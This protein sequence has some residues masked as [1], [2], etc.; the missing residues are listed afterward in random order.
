MTDTSLATNGRMG[1][2]LLVFGLA[3]LVMSA[4]VTAVL[5][6]F[7]LDAPG[8]VAIGVLVA[9]TVIA[10][11]TFVLGHRR[12]LRRG[13]QL[14]FA[15]LALGLILLISLLQ[16]VVLVPMVVGKAELPAL[17]AEVQT[18]I[19]ANMAVMALVI[20]VV[21]LLYFAI[22]YF[23]SGWFSRR[24]SMRLATTGRI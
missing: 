22:L 23:T 11:R 24:F 9:A 15:L 1:A 3:Y 14:R 16:L 7:N 20:T 2:C 5:V 19:A 13:E 18:G 4:L 8:G 10:A 12:P 6:I 21:V 17:I